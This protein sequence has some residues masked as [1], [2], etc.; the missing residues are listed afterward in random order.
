MGL[1]NHTFVKYLFIKTKGMKTIWTLLMSLVILTQ[2]QAQDKKQL[3]KINKK[4]N[5][6]EQGKIFAKAKR[7]AILGDNLR[8]KIAAR[9]I[10]EASWKEDNYY[11]FA[12]YAVLD[13]LSDEL[14]QEITNTYHLNLK[15]RF[16]ELGIEVIPYQELMAAKSYKK[17]LDKGLKDT[18]NVKKSW[19][20]A[21][22]YNYDRNP[23][24]SW[25]S[26]GPFGPHQ[27]IPKELDAVLFNSLVTIDFAEIGIDISKSTKKNGTFG[28]RKTYTEAKSSVVPVI[29]IDG[30]TYSSSGLKMHEDNTFL[31]CINPKGK[32]MIMKLDL[33]PSEIESDIEFVEEIEKCQDCQPKFTKGFLKMM[34]Q[35]MGTIIIKVDPELYKKAVL[36]ALDQ[37]LD[38]MFMVI[39]NQRK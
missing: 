3:K 15:K 11:K 6:F 29:N 35:G 16:E 38:E 23:Y 17:L 19:G 13:G 31:F 21:Y 18:E 12:F 27:K 10:E 32:Q 37:Y 20:V 26:A 8:F 22:I 34:E 4:Y 24:I 36:D 28:S 39:N 1:L 7:V 14:L 25:S 30:Y 2:I 33:K 9:Q 5:T